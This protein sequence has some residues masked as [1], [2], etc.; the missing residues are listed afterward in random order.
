MPPSSRCKPPA[1]LV[2]AAAVL[3][4]VWGLPA[5]AMADAIEQ[6]VDDKAPVVGWL[7]IVT[8]VAAGAFWALDALMRLSPP[9][10][11]PGPN[12]ED[13]APGEGEAG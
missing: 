8:I 13:P 12:G 7:I 11:P 4:T 9:A 10:E 6:T 2:S 1:S 3:F 5:T